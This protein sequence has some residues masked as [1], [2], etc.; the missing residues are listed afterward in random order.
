M[1]EG[2]GSAAEEDEGKGEGSQGQRK[3]V[4]PGTHQSLVQVHF[5]DG[6][7]EIDADRKS[8]HSSEQADQDQQAA[9]E[10]AEGREVSAPGGKS[11]AGNKLNML[12]KAAEDLVITVADHDG[13]KGKTHDEK[14][15]W[16]QAIEVAHVI[17][18]KESE[19]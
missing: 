1:I 12:V 7:A 5:R 4:S 19:R 10:F 11:E 17:P 16:L 18:P 8:G 9:K 2:D 15:E 6:D 13:A 3:F 14:R